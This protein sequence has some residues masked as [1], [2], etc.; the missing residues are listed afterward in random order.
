MANLIITFIFIIN[1]QILRVVKEN[2]DICINSLCI[3]LF[4]HMFLT[5]NPP[6]VLTIKCIYLLNLQLKPL[7]YFISNYV[8]APPYMYEIQSSVALYYYHIN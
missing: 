6:I 7:S 3:H 4:I 2:K 1:G 8:F 5:Y